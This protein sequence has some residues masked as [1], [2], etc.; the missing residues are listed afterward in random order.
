MHGVP[1]CV[2]HNGIG[3]QDRFHLFEQ[4]RALLLI[5]N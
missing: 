3:F 1:A 4:Q 5:R 2:H